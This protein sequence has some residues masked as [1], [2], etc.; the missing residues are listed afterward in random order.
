[1]PHLIFRYA[2]TPNTSNTTAMTVTVMAATLPMK[3][4][5]TGEEKTPR[6]VIQ[7]E[8]ILNAGVNSVTK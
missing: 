5:S 8:A 4:E 1:M 6:E 2:A 3:E 7:F